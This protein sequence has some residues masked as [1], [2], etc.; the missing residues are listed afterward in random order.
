MYIGKDGRQHYTLKEKYDYYKK[1]ANSSTSK[2]KQGGTIP[3]TGRVALAN[4][5]NSIKRRMGRNKR[6]FDSITGAGLTINVKQ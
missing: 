5:A 4:K 3:F 6:Q 1:K 2:N